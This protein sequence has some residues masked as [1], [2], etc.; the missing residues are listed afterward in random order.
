MSQFMD[1]IFSLN[2]VEYRED[3]FKLIDISSQV[4]NNQ[5]F[6]LLLIMVSRFTK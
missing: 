1:K 6:P 3:A 2:Y 5:T 4:H